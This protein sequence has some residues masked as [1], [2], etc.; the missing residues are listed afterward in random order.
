MFYLLDFSYSVI[1][2]IGL[3]VPCTVLGTNHNEKLYFPNNQ[4][5]EE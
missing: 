2:I 1:I 5:G 3:L 4:K